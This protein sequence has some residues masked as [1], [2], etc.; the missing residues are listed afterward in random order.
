MKKKLPIQTIAILA[1]I[2]V[3]LLWPSFTSEYWTYY[4]ALIAILS[5]MSLSFNICLGYTGMVSL[6]HTGMY[7]MGAYFTG[8]IMTRLGL[9]FTVTVFMVFGI[10]SLTG[11]LVSLAS[12]R[13][14]AMHFALITSAFNT[15]IQE[16]AIGLK[17]FF[18]GQGGMS[19][20]PRPTWGGVRMNMDQYYYVI[21]G[22][23]FLIFY[24]Y[25]NLIRSQYG[26]A[27]RSISASAEGAA[28]L[29]IRPAFYKSLSFS[30]VAG[31]AGVAGCLYGSLD[32]FM[33]PDSMA[34]N[35]TLILYVGLMLGGSGTIVGPILGVIL[36]QIIKQQLT[37]YPRIQAL[38]FGALLLL[39]IFV[40]PK[41]ILGTINQVQEAIR[42][43]KKERLAGESTGVASITRPVRELIE[44]VVTTLDQERG[45]SNIL[46]VLG[47]KKHFGGVKAL[48]GVDMDVKSFTVHG[49][50]GPNGSGKSTLMNVVGGVYSKTAGTVLFNGE[51]INLPQYRVAQKGIVRVFQIPHLFDKMTVLDNILAGFHINYKENFFEVIFGLP[52]Y[53]RKEAELRR[54]AMDLIE[55]AGLKGKEDDRVAKLS[56]GQKRMLEVV[57][58]LA[59]NPQLLMLDEPATGLTSSELDTI[60]ELI[61][62]LKERGITIL[63]VEHNM[64]F[65]MG[66]SDY[67]TVFD[68]GKKISEGLPVEVQSDPR[69]IEAYLGSAG[70]KAEESRLKKLAEK[71]ALQNA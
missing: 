62:L 10:T 18:G 42:E 28:S 52:S 41:G 48:D 54:K 7:A 63:L 57:R 14:T 71:E 32:G 8:I 40:M 53:R 4:L 60:S 11:L 34:G 29:G 55:L 36:S 56:H 44:T 35:A 64:K 9:P 43:K 31:L 47:L 65:V 68:D 17:G 39:I 16:L 22:V 49:L 69:V 50:V 70:V 67:V 24:F 21:I 1:I 37:A 6:I 25:Y 38:A 30:I 27:F 5:I 61:L 15:A 66:L 51:E 45:S 13:A 20:I 58:A 33:S 3:V 12:L 19:G 26:R 2:L 59:V 23:F 46:E